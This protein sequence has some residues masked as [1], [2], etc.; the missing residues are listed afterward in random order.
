LASWVGERGIGR[1]GGGGDRLEEEGLL[2]ERGGGDDGVE[3]FA[4]GL[5]GGEEEGDVGGEMEEDELDEFECVEDFAARWDDGWGEGDG[6]FLRG[7]LRLLLA[8]LFTFF[9]A[10]GHFPGFRVDNDFVGDFGGTTASCCLKSGVA[11]GCGLNP[12]SRSPCQALLCLKNGA[13]DRF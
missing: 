12:E 5:E 7:L 6:G 3:G 10:L 1:G 4:D 8:Q 2:E 11:L 13:S 9:V